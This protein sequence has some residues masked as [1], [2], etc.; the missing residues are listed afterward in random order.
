MDGKRSF[1][2]VSVKDGRRSKGEA[3]TGGRFISRTPSGAARK[4]GSHICRKTAIHGQCTLKLCI[5]ETTRGSARKLYYYTI[6]RVKEPR[7]VLHE[8]KM[9]TYNYKTVVRKAIKKDLPV[10]KDLP[11]M[12][13][14][15]PPVYII[16]F[17]GGQFQVV[18]ARPHQQFALNYIMDNN[19][20][21]WRRSAQC[22]IDGSVP[23]NHIH[24]PLNSG[25]F[26]LKSA[27]FKL[28]DTLGIPVPEDEFNDVLYTFTR[29]DS[30]YPSKLTSKTFISRDR[31]LLGKIIENHVPVLRAMLT[32]PE[33]Y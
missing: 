33:A 30:M 23:N 8:G 12:K 28:L 19:I 26:Y 18:P 2:I 29:T 1:T 6:K 3:N 31:R 22:Y 17:D 25:A 27:G 20:E 10:K 13:G 15:A 14:G 32:N 5:E 16:I 4:A 7:K 21:T 11:G 9:V 24:D